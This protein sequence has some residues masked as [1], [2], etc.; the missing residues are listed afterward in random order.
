VDGRLAERAGLPGRWHALTVSLVA[1]FMTLLDT[2]IVN[3]ALPSIER[4]LGA[5]AT[6]AQWV[7]SGYAL[8]FGLALVPAGRLG[9]ALG[10]RRMFLIALSAF[11][12]TSALSGAAP[13]ARLLIAARLLQSVAGGTLLPQGSGLIQ[14]LF[15][16]AERGRAFGFLGATVGLATAAGPVIGGL[17]LA[18]FAG[19]DGWR[20]V[21]YVN[22]PISL[23]A[24]A[25]P[26]GCCRPPPGPASAA[27]TWTWSGRCCF[28]SPANVG[29]PSPPANRD[30][31][32][33]H[34]QPPA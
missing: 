23:V 14:E 30:W 25:W 32:V 29:W 9:D 12:A 17:L 19:P 26:P 21:F 7:V 13:T 31:R 1:S 6:S 3:L 22:L 20:W 2:S 33:G 16:G 8:A 34:A 28:Q 18:A 27:S 24:L 10:R 4:D 15:G 5:S 11:V